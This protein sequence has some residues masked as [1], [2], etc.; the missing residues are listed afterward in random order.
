MRSDRLNHIDALVV[1][2]ARLG[3]DAS[4]AV[5]RSLLDAMARPGHP[6]PNRVDPVGPIPPLLLAA[7]A[8]VDLDHVVA[9]LG[10]DI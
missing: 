3:G 5:F 8:L 7:L 2:S 1:S 9:V 4:L 6:A 10:D